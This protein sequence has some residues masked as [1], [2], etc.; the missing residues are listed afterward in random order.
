MDCA[1]IISITFGKNPGQD[2]DNEL[3]VCAELLFNKYAARLGKGVEV[4]ISAQAMEGAASELSES[5]PLF[6]PIT[7]QLEAL[8]HIST[9]WR[10]GKSKGLGLY[11]QLH[12]NYAGSSP[13][14]E[15]LARLVAYLYTKFGLQFRKIN[16]SL[17]YSAGKK[18]V[19]DPSGSTAN[20]FCAKL[21][22]TLQEHK[23]WLTGVMVAGY[24]MF[25]T[26]SM[27]EDQVR[28]TQELGK[29]THPRGQVPDLLSQTAEKARVGLQEKDNKLPKS[30]LMAKSKAFQDK[31]VKEY[32]VM[33]EQYVLG[34]IIWKFNGNQWARA[35][36]AEYTD[37]EPIRR[38]VVDT[39]DYLKGTGNK[40][41]FTLGLVL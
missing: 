17:C 40:E 26:F 1:G 14:P 27:V 32:W 13:S 33:A 21:L 8:Q 25:V 12:G 30:L 22:E 38:M 5:N 6:K 19:V 10:E 41:L 34:K 29:P 20:Q 2:L 23:E 37:S 16:L 28:N 18:D 24:R 35:S 3:K 11:L 39:T 9:F 36:L 4:C 7:E 31:N 15:I